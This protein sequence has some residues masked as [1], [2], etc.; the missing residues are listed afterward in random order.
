[1]TAKQND[2]CIAALAGSGYGCLDTLSDAQ[3]ERYGRRVGHLLSE[4]GGSRVV[5]TYG[6]ANGSTIE[7]YAAAQVTGGGAAATAYVS[8]PLRAQT[9]R[10]CRSVLY[11]RRTTATYI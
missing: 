3:L 1:M 6:F 11:A 5:D 7:Q 8:E 9:P 2:T 10:R 4:C